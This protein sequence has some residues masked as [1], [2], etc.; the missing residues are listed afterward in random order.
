M[1]NGHEI[2]TKYCTT[3]HLFRPPRCSHC[4]V[5]DNCIEKF[6]HHCPWV[7]TC[8]GRRN[9]R[10]FLIFIFS[11]SI[12]CALL[13]G[14]SIV[15]LVQLSSG[16]TFLHALRIEW[17]AAVVI[18][19]C[20]AG[21]IF[22]GALSGFH[23]YL[24]ATNQTTYEYFRGRGSENSFHRSLAY[25]CLEAVCGATRLYAYYGNGKHPTLISARALSESA[26]AQRYKAAGSHADTERRLDALDSIDDQ[27]NH[28]SYSHETQQGNSAR[29]E[30][31]LPTLPRRMDTHELAPDQGPRLSHLPMAAYR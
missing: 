20:V 10:A 23:A 17:A 22:V 3:C 28:A 2:I 7:G 9:Y 16:S 6:D 11:A 27:A 30:A 19:H 5:C 29:V 31:M 26:E 4:A 8:I 25:N 12:S 13:I 24:V 1:I 18:V 21:L 14:L 15:R